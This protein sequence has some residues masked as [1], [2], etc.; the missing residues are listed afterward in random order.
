MN[1]ALYSPES[2]QDWQRRKGL[3][4]NSNRGQGVLDAA[5]QEYARGA[6]RAN[7]GGSPGEYLA[8]SYNTNAILEGP[9][10][11]PL[12]ASPEQRNALAKVYDYQL[13]EMRKQKNLENAAYEDAMQTYEM[14]KRQREAS[15]G[16]LKNA[17]SMFKNLGSGIG[18]SYRISG[19]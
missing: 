9:A 1:P 10:R 7:A 19:V 14:N 16:M 15:S 3:V 6:T 8:S 11:T 13:G 5:Y 12:L 18:G 17:S 4:P 2:Q